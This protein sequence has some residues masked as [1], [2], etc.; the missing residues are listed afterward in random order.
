[1]FRY[2]ICV[3]TAVGNVCGLAF[4]SKQAIYFTMPFT[5]MVYMV[6]DFGLADGVSSL[7]NPYI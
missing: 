7:C 5:I 3:Y 1:M 6:A 4:A 2:L